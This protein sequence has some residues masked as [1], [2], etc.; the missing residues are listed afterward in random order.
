MA[1]SLFWEAGESS[2]GTWVVQG[3]ERFGTCKRGRWI[4]QHRAESLEVTLKLEFLEGSWKDLGRIL[5]GPWKDASQLCPE[6]LLT[7]FAGM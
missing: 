5:E 7:F 1:L 2:C 6:L 4:S 3:W